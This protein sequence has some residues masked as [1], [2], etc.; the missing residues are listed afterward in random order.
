MKSKRAFENHSAITQSDPFRFRQIMRNL[1]VNGFRHDTGGMRVEVTV[2]DGNA[3]V[4]VRNA[5]PAIPEQEWELIFDPYQPA[6][7]APETMGGPPSVGLGLS[8]GR[9]LAWLMEGDLT[10]FVEDGE[11]AFE[12]LLPAAR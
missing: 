10:Y 7:P 3:V 12:L 2:D 4:V 1:F 6:A 5:G 9:M 11:G 8:V